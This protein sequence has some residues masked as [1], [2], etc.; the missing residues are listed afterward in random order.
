[1]PS[2]YLPFSDADK[3]TWLNNFKTQIMANGA[4]LGF[5]AAEITSIQNDAAMFQYIVN[6]KEGSRQALQALSTLTQDLRTASALTPMGAIP[7]L[8]VAGTPPVPVANG[9]F[10]RV[11]VYVKR[12]KM[13]PN[14]T[15]TLG[16]VFDIIPPVTVFDPAT[17]KPTL[18]ARV[19]SGFPRLSWKKLEA[20]GV[21]LYVDRRDGN[22]FVLIDKLVR[23]S[24]IDT[25]ALPANTFSATW[26]YKAR[27]MIDDDEIGVDS[28]IVTVTVMRV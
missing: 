26:D 3:V 8:P 2:T 9:I 4:S 12:I 15:A 13:H 25:H 21:F 23:T 22:G 24:Y 17:A 16:Q 7:P 5:T 1:M 27:F 11:S 6:L 14:Y 19:D 10:S 20:D 18:N 28:E